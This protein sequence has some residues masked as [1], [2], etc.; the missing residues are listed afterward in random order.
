MDTAIYIHLKQMK[1]GRIYEYIF[2][3]FFHE[4]SG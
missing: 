1:V 4:M 2:I 3:R